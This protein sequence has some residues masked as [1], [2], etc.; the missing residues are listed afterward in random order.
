MPCGWH[1]GRMP[2]VRMAEGAFR[3]GDS[4]PNMQLIS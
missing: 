1:L 3:R 2:K 4:Y